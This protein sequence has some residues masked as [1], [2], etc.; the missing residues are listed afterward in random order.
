MDELGVHPS[1]FGKLEARHN[2]VEM[3]EACRKEAVAFSEDG[4]VDGLYAFTLEYL[5]RRDDASTFSDC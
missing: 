1:E 5:S 4:L 3:A 2:L